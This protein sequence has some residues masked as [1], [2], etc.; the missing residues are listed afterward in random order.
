MNHQPYHNIILKCVTWRLLVVVC[1]SFLLSSWTLIGSRFAGLPLV[2]F[3][4]EVETNPVTPFV[5]H[6]TWIYLKQLQLPII[7]IYKYLTLIY[8]KAFLYA[9]CKSVICL[10]AFA[11]VKN[12]L[13]NHGSATK[14]QQLRLRNYA[15]ATKIP[16]SAT[17]LQQLR[18]RNF[19]S[20]TKT[21]TR[22]RNFASATTLQ[23]PNSPYEKPNTDM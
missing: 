4:H 9:L 11:S 19:A 21:C 1:L 18:F 5:A 8:V 7:S 13:S 20:A 17:S 16:A 3:L 6:R 2:G 23:Q 14:S 12:R 15:T 22:F 10:H